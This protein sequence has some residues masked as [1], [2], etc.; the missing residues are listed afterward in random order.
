M[1][2]HHLSYLLVAMRKILA[3]APPKNKN[4]TSSSDLCRPNPES[5]FEVERKVWAVKTQLAEMLEAK[6]TSG[7]GEGLT[8]IEIN[9]LKMVISKLALL[10][11][12]P[13]YLFEEGALTLY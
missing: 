11:R 6:V 7:D 8:S 5:L 1:E 4:I 2:T 3:R 10:N 12:E 13:L 9:L